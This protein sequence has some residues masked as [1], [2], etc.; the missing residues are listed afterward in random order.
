MIRI[1]IVLKHLPPRK[2]EYIKYYKKYVLLK[3]LAIIK[4]NYFLYC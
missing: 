3:D 4:G 2:T 1:G